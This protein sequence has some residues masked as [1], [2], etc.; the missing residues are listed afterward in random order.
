M[1]Y[2]LMLGLVALVGCEVEGRRARV[3]V[4]LYSHADHTGLLQSQTGADIIEMVVIRSDDPFASQRKSDLD[5][6]AGKGTLPA[7]PIGEGLRIY[8]RGFMGSEGLPFFFGSSLPFDVSDDDTPAVPIQVGPSDCVCLN[9]SSPRHRLAGGKEDMNDVRVG[10]TATNL[11]DGRVLVIGGSKVDALGNVIEVASSMELYDPGRGQFMRVDVNLAEP[12][13]FHT[14]TPITNN[15]GAEQY[16]IVGGVNSASGG[17]VGVSATAEL[18]SIN[19]PFVDVQRIPGGL[20]AGEGRRDHRATTLRDGSILITGGSGADGV[21]LG[22]VWRYFPSPTADPSGARWVQQGNLRFA[23]TGHAAPALD[24]TSEHALVAGGLTETGATDSIEVFTTSAEQGGCADD[25]RATEEV[26]CW[27]TVL[28]LRLG[29]A[30]WGHEAV[31]VDEGRQVLIVGGYTSED[32]SGLARGLEL[33]D[34]SLSPRPAGQLEIGRGE[35]TA[36]VLDDDSVL[37]LGGRRGGSPTF[38]SSRLR[39]GVAPGADGTPRLAGF[40]D[41]ELQMDCDMSEPR[42]AHAAVRM[43]TGIV[44]VVGGATGRANEYVASRRAELYFPRV[45]DLSTVYPDL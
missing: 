4:E 36:T 12:R 8:V 1:R 44:L 7:L 42:F 10:A 17:V 34:G 22:S 37:V 27:I 18:L 14:V 45:A 28:D 31:R 32:R 33:I 2:I 21:G 11:R 39:P 30:R 3:P 35:L 41:T 24:R 40:E 13:A 23:R 43:L 16:L 9:A 15:G 20:P 5:I 38:V 6:G 29:E 26:G 25:L 19:G